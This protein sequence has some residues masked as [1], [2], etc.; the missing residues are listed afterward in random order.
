MS[1]NAFV[2]DR[3]TVEVTVLLVAGPGI[4]GVSFESML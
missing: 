4:A 2:A 1:V 3:L